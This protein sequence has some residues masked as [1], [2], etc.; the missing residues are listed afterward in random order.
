MMGGF[1]PV[2]KALE[3]RS[4]SRRIRVPAAAGRWDRFEIA[5][6]ERAASR[7]RA[8]K[9]RRSG[10]RLSGPESFTLR[11]Q[12]PARGKR[13]RSPAISSAPDFNSAGIANAGGAGRLIAEW[14]I[15]GRAAV[16][17]VRRGRPPLRA[18]AR[19]S[20]A[21][22]RSH[23]RI[24]RPATT[25]CA[26]RARSSSTVRPLRRSP[27]VRPVVVRRR[28]VRHEAQ[29][30]ARQPLPAARRK[31]AP[32]YTLDTPAWL[33]WM[34]TSSARMS[35]RCRRVR[36]DVVLQ[37]RAERPRR[38]RGAR[39]D[40]AR[41]DIDVD[42]RAHRS[43]RRCCNGARRIRKRPDDHARLA[44][45]RVLHPQLDRRRRHAIS[46]STERQHRRRLSIAP[47]ADVT[48]ASSVIS[49]HGAEARSRCWARMS[50][51]SMWVR[52]SVSLLATTREIDQ[53]RQQYAKWRG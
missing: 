16:R 38:A 22:G 51:G 39:S 29:L 5:D 33:P 47:L 4:Y 35:R 46:R 17:R 3:R 9:R 53:R 18:V 21:S 44:A 8:S 37:I 14:I 45:R 43:T 48:S 32:P 24:A 40:C 26:G 27:L 41:T 1:E 34:L 15:G 2:A 10:A 36:P 19:E 30:G 25:R 31:A 13:P 12:F 42:D 23:R 50:S 20:T 49:G 7:R 52:K 6:G 28:R 11:W